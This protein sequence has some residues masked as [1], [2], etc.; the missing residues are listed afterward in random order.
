MKKTVQFILIFILSFILIDFLLS[1]F[2][3]KDVYELSRN[4]I[5]IISEQKSNK[6]VDWTEIYNIWN[7]PYW[8][9]D[10]RGPYYNYKKNKESDCRVLWLG[11]SIIWWSWVEWDYTYFYNLSKMY[12]NTEF[13]NLWIPGSDA[14][15]QIIKYEKEGITDN[16]LLIWH[17]RSDDTHI[18]KNI[19]WVLYDSRIEL[20]DF[21]KLFLF[22]FIPNKVNDFLTK[23]S[24]VYNKLLLIKFNSKINEADSSTDISNSEYVISELKKVID[25]QKDKKILFLFSPPLDNDEYIF[26][27][28]HS[29]SWYPVFYTDLENEFKWNTNIHMLYLDE[30]FKW[31]KVEEIRYDTC[32]H[33]NEKWHEII[34]NKLNDFIKNN[35]ILDEKCY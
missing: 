25:S 19:D 14:L 6:Q 26:K 18:Y 8:E 9:A 17:I 33:F 4:K 29:E 5:N 24:Y 12:S 28:E 31:I 22:N 13:I 34:S 3:E 27:N 16:D 23:N 10:Y 7:I 15:Q 11:D 30:F 1:L 32:C 2:F 35:A 20:N 21:W